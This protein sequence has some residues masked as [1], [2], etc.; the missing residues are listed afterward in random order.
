MSTPP[1]RLRRSGAWLAQVPA[2]LLVLAALVPSAGARPA[3]AERRT[4]PP[5]EPITR[6]VEREFDW[7]AAAMGAGVA[8]AV[9]LLATAGASTVRGRRARRGVQP[10]PGG[11]P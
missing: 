2:V 10:H 3:D 5:R 9:V 4:V 7:G 1:S 11:R 8:A 6:T